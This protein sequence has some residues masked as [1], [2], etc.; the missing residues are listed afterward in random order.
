MRHQI[1]THQ[2][3]ISRLNNFSVRNISHTVTRTIVEMA[4]KKELKS[5]SIDFVVTLN[6]FLLNTLFFANMLHVY[7]RLSS[8]IFCIL[9]MLQQQHPVLFIFFSFYSHNFVFRI[10]EFMLISCEHKKHNRVNKEK[11][12]KKREERKRDTKQ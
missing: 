1:S 2:I 4:I 10:I 11:K 9:S 3:S 12:K 8:M 5:W 7:L 6:S